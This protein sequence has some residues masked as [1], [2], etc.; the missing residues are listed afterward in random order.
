MSP[1]SLRRLVEAP[2]VEGPDDG[3]ARNPAAAP[4]LVRYREDVAQATE[5]AYR[6]LRAL[7]DPDEA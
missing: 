3:F 1:A 5:L 7:E 6:Q 2:D 4:I